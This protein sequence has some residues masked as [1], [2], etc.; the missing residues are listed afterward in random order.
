MYHNHKTNKM[1]KLLLIL[2]VIFITNSFSQQVD[3]IKVK[4]QQFGLKKVAKV[5]PKKIFIQHF[6][7]NYQMLFDQI[8]IAKGG[9]EI[10]G[11][12]RGD[13]KAQLVLGVQG[14]SEE[15][16]Q[17]VTDKLY[18][19]YTD[20]LKAKGFEFVSVSD[21]SK[22]ERFAGWE[23]VK[24]GTPSKA[25]F[26]GYV[27]TAPNGFDFLVRKT[28]KKGKR[29]SKKNIFDNGTGVSKDLDVIVARVYINVPFMKE[30]ESQG[31]RALT[32]TFGGVAKIV[33]KPEFG[34]LKMTTVMSKAFIGEKAN[35]ITTES[36][37]VYKKNLKYQANIKTVPK[38]K[39]LIKGV[40][41]KKKYKAVKSASQD[42]WGTGYGAIRVFSASDVVKKKMQA[43][44]VDAQK[45]KNGVLE[46]GNGFLNTSLTE[47]LKH[48]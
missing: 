4:H 48:F 16:L 13:A 6:F 44:P 2:A 31:S 12:V 33:A 47:F 7:V 5:I 9:R 32:K 37:F 26:P 39:I 40:F 29:K 25:Q 21:A 28:T 17:E 38:K 45:Y 18:K 41:A 14:V 36:N 23:I 1:K 24:G 42:L 15:D 43:I 8:E 10:G 22:L 34:L 46:A 20:R 30:A 27:S 3:E 19:E 11:G 35:T